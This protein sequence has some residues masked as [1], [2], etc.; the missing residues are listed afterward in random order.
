LSNPAGLLPLRRLSMKFSLGQRGLT[1][2]AVQ[3]R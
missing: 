2:R 1:K 3:L